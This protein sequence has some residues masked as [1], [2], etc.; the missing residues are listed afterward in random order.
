MFKSVGRKFYRFQVVW[1]FFTQ[2][3][4]ILIRV[5]I[6]AN[7]Q[8]YIR[9]YLTL[10]NLRRIKFDRPVDFY[11]SAEKKDPVANSRDRNG[12]TDLHDIWHDDAAWISQVHR[13]SAVLDIFKLNFTPHLTHAFTRHFD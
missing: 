9:L 13:P 8:N 11:I 4:R 3:P 5:R 10:T 12:T 6:Y 2:R 1:K 7:L